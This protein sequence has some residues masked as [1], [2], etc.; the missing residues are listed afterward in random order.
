MRYLYMQN[1]ANDDFFLSISRIL[2]TEE[3]FVVY[4]KYK[5]KTLTQKPKL[6]QLQRL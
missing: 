3:F 4:V 6:N 1:K 2:G 5:T